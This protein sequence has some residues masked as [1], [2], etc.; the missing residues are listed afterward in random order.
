MTG[1][2]GTVQPSPM[3]VHEEGIQYVEFVDSGARLSREVSR[4]AFETFD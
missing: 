3:D 4:F 2:F 1:D